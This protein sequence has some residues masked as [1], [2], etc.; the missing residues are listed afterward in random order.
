MMCRGTRYVILA[1]ASYLSEADVADMMRV[2]EL[3]FDEDEEEDEC[4]C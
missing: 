2:N 3:L 4:A 1:F